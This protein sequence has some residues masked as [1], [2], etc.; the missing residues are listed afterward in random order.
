LNFRSS[1]FVDGIIIGIFFIVKGFAKELVNSLCC[2][3]DAPCGGLY[4]NINKKRNSKTLLFL[5]YFIN[6]NTNIN[7]IVHFLIY[8]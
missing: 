2:F 7:Q 4:I 1:C 8:T 6:I 5:L 3:I